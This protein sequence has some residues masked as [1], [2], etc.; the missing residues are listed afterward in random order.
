MNDY[1]KKLQGG[2]FV[3][4]KRNE[5]LKYYFSENSMF[6]ID[7]WESEII[8]GTYFDELNK[9][10]I[11]FDKIYLS[12][13]FLKNDMTTEEFDKMINW[14]MP[15]LIIDFDKKKL[16]NNFYDQALEDRIPENWDGSFI[17]NR[18]DFLQLIPEK[19]NYWK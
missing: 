19:M 8:N 12:I 10:E 6:L 5:T 18:N 16:I 13:K 14:K 15:Q 2:I 11:P 17:E 3:L 9:Y 4:V 1:F 7:D